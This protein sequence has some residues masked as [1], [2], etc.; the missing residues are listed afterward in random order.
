MSTPPKLL[1]PEVV[2]VASLKPHERNYRSHPEDQL[3]HLESS[4]REFGVYRNVVVARDGTILAGHGIVE[5]AKRLGLDE[6]RVAR[7]DVGPDDPAAIRVLTGDNELAR[8]AES[9]DRLLAELLRDL[10]EAEGGL[11]GTGY[12]DAML[13]NLVYVTRPREEISTEGD[14]AAWTG[15]PD[16]GQTSMPLRVI[17]SF[18]NAEDRSAFLTLIGVETVHKKTHETLSVWWPERPREDLSSLRFEE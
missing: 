16:F 10:R 6:I 2:K 12:D 4:L 7:L 8:F 13:A 5:A 1:E 9:N 11:L 17:V 18:D 15:L 3:I 14:A